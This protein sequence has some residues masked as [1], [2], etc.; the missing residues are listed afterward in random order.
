MFLEGKS[1]P[2]QQKKRTMAHQ[3][4]QNVTLSLTLPISCQICL[5][6]VREP[7]IC[8]NCHVF[9]SFCIEL[10]LNKTSQCPTCRIPITPDNPC[11]K[12]IG[13]TNESESKESRSVKRHLRKTRAE[14]L[15]REYED[16]IEG[17]EKEN[18]ELRRRNANAE[19]RLE[20]LLLDPSTPGAESPKMRARDRDGEEPRVD[21]LLLEAEWTNKR[22]AD[23]T[24]E[25]IKLDM[26]KFKE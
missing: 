17:V 8:G 16:E 23:D 5:G 3:S 18:D 19:R 6:K 9:C 21:A 11:R 14:L 2:R 7:V 4:V 12:I 13:G 15:L 26:E 10:W 22:R 24:G 1:V 25:K 20:A